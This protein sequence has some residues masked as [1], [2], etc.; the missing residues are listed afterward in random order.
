MSIEFPHEGDCTCT[1]CMNV[2]RERVRCF[3]R[4][5]NPDNDEVFIFRFSDKTWEE[6]QRDVA[7]AKNNSTL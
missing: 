6:F 7:A 2:A 4:G 3:N 1:Y 5:V